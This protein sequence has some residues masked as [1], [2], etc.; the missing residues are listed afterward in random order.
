MVA[1]QSL[2]PIRDS[3]TRPAHTDYLAGHGIGGQPVELGTNLSDGMRTREPDRVGVDTRRPQ[4][5][6]LLQPHL[7]LLRELSFVCHLPEATVVPG[8]PGRS[9]P[10]PRSTVFRS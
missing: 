1:K 6:G 9:V 2:P 4:P 8:T 3:M 10:L 7:H 5:I